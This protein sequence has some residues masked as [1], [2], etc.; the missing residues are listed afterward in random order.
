MSEVVAKLDDMG[1]AAWVAVMVL[2]FVAFW[3]A[4]LAILAYLIWSGRMSC[5][6]NWGGQG[7]G[8]SRW[9][10]KMQRFQDKMDKWQGSSGGAG[11]TRTYAAGFRP[12]GNRA[13]DDYRDMTMKRLE[14]EFTEFKSF[15]DRLREA[16]DKS[17]F[18]QF[19]SDRRNRTASDQGGAQS[20]GQPQSPRGGD[21]PFGGGTPPRV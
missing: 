8:S 10:R 9:E 5:G 6:R 3:P 20:Q 17:E 21:Y 4:G 7:D 19:M 1:H 14:E 12:S 13:F 2:G 18:E 16:K 15:L 11:S